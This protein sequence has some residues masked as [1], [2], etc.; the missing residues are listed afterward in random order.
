MGGYV[1]GDIASRIAV[2][3]LH[4]CFRHAHTP[5]GTR[6]P[7][8]T[9]SR[10][11]QWVETAVRLAD[12]RIKRGRRG[13][14]AGMSSTVA[15]LYLG[16]EQAVIAHVGDSRVYRLRGAKLEALTQDHSLYAALAAATTGLPER[17]SFPMR[18]V[19]T[20]ALGFDHVDS[21]VQVF[22]LAEGDAFLLCSD[23]LHDH[24][25]EQLLGT[26]LACCEPGE[27]A[28]SLVEAAFGAGSADNI[29]GVVVLVGERAAI[30][31]GENPEQSGERVKLPTFLRKP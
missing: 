21:E 6:G 7:N 28:S 10:A 15:A 3:T 31:F 19:I 23:G 14:L 26:I 27:A 18:N 11:E 8:G 4:A 12:R 16:E 25:D 20:Q 5:S 22:D 24:V 30:D 2:E 1:G 13:K 29:T 17:S 9:A